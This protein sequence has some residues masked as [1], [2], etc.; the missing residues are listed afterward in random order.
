MRR[1][2]LD[3]NL[4][5]RSGAGVRGAGG[6]RGS[7]LSLWSESKRNDVATGRVSL[8]GLMVSLC[9]GLFP[10][11]YFEQKNEGNVSS[12]DSKHL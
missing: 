4:T 9:G 12:V 11:F 3:Q 6:G 10:T 1:E 2:I 7:G 8:P 5:G